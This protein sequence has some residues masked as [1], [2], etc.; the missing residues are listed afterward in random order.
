VRE[1][2][3]GAGV[4]DV[5]EPAQLTGADRIHSPIRFSTT[6]APPQ[7]PVTS[8]LD[9]QAGRKGSHKM[10]T[11]SLSLVLVIA[12]GVFPAHAFA[13]GGNFRSKVDQA[14]KR[15]LQSESQRDLRLKA[16]EREADRGIASMGSSNS[17]KRSPGS[18]AK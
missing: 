2:L 17:P 4:P 6:R 14:H 15:V 1:G 13:A 16:I 10:R 18:K 5:I 8:S 7:T 9:D 11:I 12:L 3:A